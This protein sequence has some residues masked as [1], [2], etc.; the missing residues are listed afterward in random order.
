M[1]K[2]KVTRKSHA[3]REGGQ[4]KTY[5]AGDQLDVTEREL[6]AFG[7]RL[8]RVEERKPGRPKKADKAPEPDSA[9]VTDAP[10]DG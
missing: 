4:L 9:E 6:E 1:A 10:N 7:D 3:R 5:R 8:E 2:A